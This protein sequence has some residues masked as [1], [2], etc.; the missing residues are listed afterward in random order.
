MC[1][2]HRMVQIGGEDKTIQDLRSEGVSAKDLKG[3]GVDVSDLYAAGFSISE[4]SEADFRF[5]DFSR[6]GLEIDWRWHDYGGCSWWGWFPLIFLTWLSSLA[7]LIVMLLLAIAVV[8]LAKLIVAVIWPAYISAGWLRIVAHARRRPSARTCCEPLVQGL[9]AGYQVVWASS[10]LTN[11]CISNR[12]LQAKWELVEQ[13]VGEGL[14]FAKGDRAELSPEI[15]SLSLFPPVLV[16]LFH[17]SWDL[18]LRT[19][20]H[21]LGVSPNMVQEA[22]RGLARQMMWFC[23]AAVEEGL[24]TDEWVQEVPVGLCIG[25]PARAFLQAVERS[26]PRELVLM[27]GLRVSA[28][29]A[30]ELGGFAEKVWT[31][32]CKAQDARNQVEITPAVHRLL[33]ARLLAGGEEPGTLPPTLADAVEQYENLSEATHAACQRVLQPLLEFGLACGEQRQF[34]ENLK[35]IIES[36]PHLDSESI[37][38]YLYQDP[39]LNLEDGRSEGQYVFAAP[40]LDLEAQYVF[41]APRADL[42]V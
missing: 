24:I 4:L 14:E 17:N 16:G 5:G 18:S 28:D 7:C 36:L 15:R 31:L 13:T 26:P 30:A 27:G 37:L 12:T 39:R 6:A 2:P 19:L 42:D 11:I 34:K 9:K 40:L 22:W 20:A 29:R 33:C 3:L 41:A 32:F 10:L 21:R 38:Q 8:S 1:A 25:L 23:Q 35:L